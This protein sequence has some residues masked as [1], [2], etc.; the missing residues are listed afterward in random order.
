MRDR[1]DGRNRE[2]ERERE[3]GRR[4]EEEEREAPIRGSAPRLSAFKQ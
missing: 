3:R 4:E 2:K 1:R